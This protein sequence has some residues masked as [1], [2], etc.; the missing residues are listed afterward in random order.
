MKINTDILCDMIRSYFAQKLSHPKSLWESYIIEIV[1]WRID[2]CE[3]L[4]QYKISISDGIFQTHLV[5]LDK[6]EYENQYS[7]MESE[8]RNKKIESI[9]NPWY[10]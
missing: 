6:V 2:D 5:R 7:N 3:I 4:T 8:E 1:G 10:F 9:L